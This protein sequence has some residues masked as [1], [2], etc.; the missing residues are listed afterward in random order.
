MQSSHL[1]Q[2]Q[3]RPAP[4]RRR[5]EPSAQDFI[6]PADRVPRELSAAPA[7]SSILVGVGFFFLVLWALPDLAARFSS[8][9]VCR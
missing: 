1:E 7:L 2:S 9:G 3:H 4:R 6:H 5:F 8:W